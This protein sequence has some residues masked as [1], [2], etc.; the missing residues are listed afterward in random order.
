MV[1][2][3]GGGGAG[4]WVGGLV[5]LGGWV[6]GCFCWLGG[7]VVGCFVVCGGLGWV[8]GGSHAFGYMVA[9]VASWKPVP[10]THSAS[11]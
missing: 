1:G 4:G 9:Q 6:V 10:S 7:W 3:F 11:H 8:V 2:C 5:W